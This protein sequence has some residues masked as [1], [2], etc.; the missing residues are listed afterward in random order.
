M[1]TYI[2]MYVHVHVHTCM[3]SDSD[4]RG[5]KC[6]R[7]NAQGTPKLNKTV[8]TQLSKSAKDQDRHLVNLQRFVSDCIKLPVHVIATKPIEAYYQPG[9]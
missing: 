4:R 9:T 2:Y 5:M 7:L 1:Y 3:Y 6:L 8:L